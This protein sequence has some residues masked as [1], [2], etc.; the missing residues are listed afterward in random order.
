MGGVRRVYRHADE[1]AP[2]RALTIE[3]DGDSVK[4]ICD[5]PGVAS[6]SHV[7][8]WQEWQ[9]LARCVLV[10]HLKAGGE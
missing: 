2:H 7:L 8:G 3:A 1:L 4:V 5:Q 10:G 6:V 9:E